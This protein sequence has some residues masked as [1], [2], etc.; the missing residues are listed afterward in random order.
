MRR[1]P[2]GRIGRFPGLWYPTKRICRVA[3]RRRTPKASDEPERSRT[4]RKWSIPFADLDRLW[5]AVWES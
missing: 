4:C 1:S 5:D 3:K 2:R